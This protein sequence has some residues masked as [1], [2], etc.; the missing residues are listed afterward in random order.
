MPQTKTWTAKRTLKLDCGHTINP[1]DQF[2]VT[3]VY[4]CKREAPWPWR[5]LMACFNVIQQKRQEQTKQTQSP[6]PDPE[7]YPN[8]V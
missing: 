3:T 1:G 6:V 2:M 4:S 5:I 8:G 7:D